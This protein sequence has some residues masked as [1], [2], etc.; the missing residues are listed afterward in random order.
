MKRQLKLTLGKA[1]SINETKSIYGVFAEIGA[2]Q[3][4]VNCFFKA[5][6]ASQTVAKSMSAYDMTFSNLIYGKETRYVGRHRLMNMLKHEYRLL[7]NRLRKKM[8][9]STCFFAFASTATTLSKQNKNPANHHGWIGLRFQAKPMKAFNDVILHVN[10]LDKNR[11]QQHEALGILGV[12]LIYSCFYN[13]HSIKAFVSSLME[14]LDTGRVRINW[15]NCEG[16]DMKKF[17]QDLINLELLKQEISPLA[18]FNSKG[19]S[20]FIKDSLFQAPLLIITGKMTDKDIL[21]RKL[22]SEKSSS[23]WTPVFHIPLE[24]FKGKNITGHIKRVTRKKKALLV[25]PGKD[26]KNL[27]QTLN[28]YAKGKLHF[29]ISKEDFENLFHSNTASSLL[30]TLGLL[31]DGNTKVSVYGNKTFSLQEHHFQEKDKQLLKEYL[32]YRK[33]LLQIP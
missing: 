7:Q 1:F 17:H 22:Y 24:E 13:T 21:L 28:F 20:E 15:I 18:F 3:E 33:A 14:N 31:F 16:P 2:G 32:I 30:S 25:F 19:E 4:T 6:L 26:L 12:N 5:G 11:L 27:K 23:S 9:S 10:C 8:G 29:V